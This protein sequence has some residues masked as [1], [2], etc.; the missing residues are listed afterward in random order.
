MNDQE[1]K[2]ISS[3]LKAVVRETVNGKIDRLHIKIDALV[4]KQDAHQKKMKPVFEVYDTAKRGGEFIKWFSGVIIAMGVIWAAA[5]GHI[6][7]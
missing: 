6:K 2:Q 1:L 4:E 5:K 3:D 7:L